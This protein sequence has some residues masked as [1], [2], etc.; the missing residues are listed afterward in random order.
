MKDVDLIQAL[1]RIKVQT[2]GLICLGCGHEHNCGV[3][4]CAVIREAVQRLEDLMWRDADVE[5]PAEEDVVHLVKVTGKYRNIGFQGAVM[6]AE[7][8]QQEGW[9]V[10][11]FPEWKN[12]GVTQWMP[13]P[14]GE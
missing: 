8:S 5:I 10:E 7:Y 2:G 6:T 1:K 12:P 13:I 9:I 4:G 14:M 3:H 11:L